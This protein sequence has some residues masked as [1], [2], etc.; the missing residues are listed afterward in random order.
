MDR[1][2]SH[3]E[4]IA[5]LTRQLEDAKAEAEKWRIRFQGTTFFNGDEA[6]DQTIESLRKEITLKDGI[7]SDHAESILELRKENEELRKA[8][9]GLISIIESAGNAS[10]FTY[11]S[12]M[13]PT[14]VREARKLLQKVPKMGTD[15]KNETGYNQTKKA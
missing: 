13:I 12:S 1:P 9:G 3:E 10:S 7:I 4:Y 5:D 15:R 11:S 6:K 2:M 14:I 8:L